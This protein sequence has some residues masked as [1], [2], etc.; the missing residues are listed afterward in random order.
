M[1]EE[2]ELTPGFA[3]CP[4]PPPAPNVEF[5][6]PMYGC[7]SVFYTDETGE[8]WMHNWCDTHGKPDECPEAIKRIYSRPEYQ[9]L[10]T[11]QIR[12]IWSA[13]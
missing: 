13:H 10:V 9:R 4:L 6:C 2:T 12:T 1:P 7:G 11:P 5:T 3:L 8:F